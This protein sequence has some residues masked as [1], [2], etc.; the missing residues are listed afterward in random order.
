MVALFSQNIMKKT[1]V[2]INRLFQIT[3]FDISFSESSD[4]AN[5]CEEAIPGCTQGE[6]SYYI[7]YF[8]TKQH[9]TK[10]FKQ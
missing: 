2:Y 4:I 5:E 1:T 3:A 7:S 10:I 8:Y 6:T 9:M